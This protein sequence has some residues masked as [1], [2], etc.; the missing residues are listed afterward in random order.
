MQQS[1]NNRGMQQNIIKK[2]K[3]DADRT[4]VTLKYLTHQAEG[5]YEKDDIKSL[6]LNQKTN[7]EDGKNIFR[8]C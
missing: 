7:L 1:G 3:R 5:A 8:R 6:K 2:R 4:K